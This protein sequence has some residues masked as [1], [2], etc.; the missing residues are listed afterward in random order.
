[1]TEDEIRAILVSAVKEGILNFM[2]HQGQ[3]KKLY[4]LK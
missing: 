1:M 3:G 2:Y 4:Y